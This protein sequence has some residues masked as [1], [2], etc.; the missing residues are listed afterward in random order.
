MPQW[1]NLPVTDDIRAKIEMP[2]ASV[3]ADGVATAA[4]YRV[5]LAAGLRPLSLYPYL[6]ATEGTTGPVFEYPEA[7]ALA[8]LMP[9]EQAAYLAAKA[10]AQA[11]GTLFFTRGHH[12]FIGEVID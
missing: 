9:D 2:A 11:D 6:V 12:C 5:A 1:W 3:H 10:Q 8:Q 4:I 7:Y